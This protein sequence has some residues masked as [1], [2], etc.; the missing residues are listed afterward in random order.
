MEKNIAYTMAIQLSQRL[1]N[2]KEYQKMAEVGILADDDRIELLEGKLIELSPVG[3]K[4]AA[5]VKR[6]TAL[7]YDILAGELIISV[8]GPIRLGEYSE[9][10]PDLALLELSSNY[11]EDHLPEAKNVLLII[12]V[13]DSSLEK[14]RA[15]KLPIYAGAGIPEYWVVSLEARSVEVYRSPRGDGYD[16]QETFYAES[17]SKLNLPRSGRALSVDS[18]FV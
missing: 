8:Q 2:V 6:L 9:P 16:F 7:L 3:R 12:E 10:E 5:M 18:L 17:G 13:A 15:V 11:Y 14:D 4:H 1:I